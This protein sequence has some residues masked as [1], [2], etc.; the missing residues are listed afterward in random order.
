MKKISFIFAILLLSASSFAQS[1]GTGSF[2][3][4]AYTR[5]P[6][7]YRFPKHTTGVN[8]DAPTMIFS[9]NRQYFLVFITTG[10]AD[11][12]GKLVLYKSSNR[13]VLWSSSGTGAGS[14]VMQTDGNLVIYKMSDER[15][16]PIQ[17]RNPAWSTNTHG[18]N[19]AFL[20]VQ[21]DGNVVIYN[22]GNNRALWATG[23][24]GR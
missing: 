3:G 11:V 7:G 1:L 14:C 19:G 17:D 16:S 5:V 2:G 9:P 6:S 22:S 24:N 10:A 20:A 8:T 13:Q 23:T 21:N 15:W 18:N 12:A 4:V